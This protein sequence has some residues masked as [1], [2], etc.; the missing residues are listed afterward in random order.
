MKINTKEI[1]NW[2][3]LRISFFKENWNNIED[4]TK[5]IILRYTIIGCVASSILMT[6]FLFPIRIVSV[7]DTDGLESPFV[8]T[9][10]SA[11]FF[12]V[13]STFLLVIALYCYWIS[14]KVIDRIREKRNNT[15]E[16]LFL[17]EEI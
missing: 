5:L 2:F 3:L 7:Y 16:E 4:K 6:I 13:L 1:K 15:K 10:G 8:L 9:A 14:G 11:I 17:D 12:L